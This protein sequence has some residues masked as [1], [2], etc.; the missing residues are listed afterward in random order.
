MHT[1]V[2]ASTGVEH[3]NAVMLLATA[4]VVAMHSTAR[5]ARVVDKV[6]LQLPLVQVVGVIV[7][8]SAGHAAKAQS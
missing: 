7:E 4:V 2:T 6:Y 3:E 8:R 5:L 1:S